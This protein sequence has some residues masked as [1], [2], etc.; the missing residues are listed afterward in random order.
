LSLAF[1]RDAA[2]LTQRRIRDY[3]SILILASVAMVAWALTGR[4]IDDP[5]GRPVGTDFISFWT[6]SWALLHDRTHAIY[7]PEALAALERSV[8]QGTNTFYAWLYPPIALFIV[9]P[10]A[11]LPYLWS[12][13]VWLAAG[14]ALYLTAL[15]R[16]LPRPLALWAGLAF[17]A[18]LITMEHGQN[19]FLTTG[20]VTWALLL[21]PRRPVVAGILIGLLT[22]KPQLGLLVPLAL[23]AGR[24][25]RALIAAAATSLTLAAA[26][27]AAFG[28]HIWTEYLTVAPLARELLDFALVPAYK[29]Q[30]VY[31]ASR[32]IGASATA[33]YG[34]QALATLGSAL[35][36][37]WVWRQ[38]ADQELKN[39]ALIAA[40]PLATPFILDYDLMLLAPVI[41]WLAAKGLRS[42]ALSWEGITLTAAALEPLV[43]RVVGQYTHVALTPPL[44]IALLTLIVRRI[45]VATSHNPRNAVAS[46]G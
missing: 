44:L 39:A 45:R 16:I 25:W 32:L 17:P 37:L 14:T 33:A 5:L 1:F 21:L 18:V 10:L 40:T 4:G 6:V 29:M 43:A 46:F 23:I 2:W 3:S 22:F 8:E 12:L 15:W 19:A 38:P 42:G 30:S 26:T 31:T 27:M 24:H 9:Y 34:V 36:I 11:F 13:L 20:L 41:A 7:M 28:P 35:V